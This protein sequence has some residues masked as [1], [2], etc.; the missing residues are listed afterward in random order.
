M[1]TLIVVPLTCLALAAG[2][3]SSDK[4]RRAESTSETNQ[5]LL[6]ET[7]QRAEVARLFTAVSRRTLTAHTAPLAL[8]LLSSLATGQK[9]H[10]ACG[11]GRGMAA[12]AVSGEIYPCHR[13]VGLKGT[14]LGHLHDYRAGELNNY[15]RAVVD[16][17]PVCRGCWAR[18]LCGGGCFYDHQGHT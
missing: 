5:K 10:V 16:N 17:L 4:V 1:K 2:C 3:A 13:F 14:R 8:I 15:H 12:V 7:D 6:R 11:I 9:R 18:Y